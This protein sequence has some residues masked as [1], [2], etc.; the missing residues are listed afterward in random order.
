MSKV[1]NFK[2]P[3]SIDGVIEKV[4]EN[5]M[6]FVA[7]KAR[8]KQSIENDAQY[9]VALGHFISNAQKEMEKMHKLGKN[10]EAS[11]IQI[12]IFDAI[13]KY[14]ANEGLVNDKAT[15]F[16][17]VFLPM[18]EKELEESGK[19]FGG[20][21]QQCKEALFN[22]KGVENKIVGFIEKEVEKYETSADKEDVELK[23]YT[24][25]ILKRLWNKLQE[26]SQK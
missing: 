4:K 18:Y 23:N 8:M 15:H 21:L 9:L 24:Y 1:V 13:G 22:M 25:K 7:P 2:A 26:D 5:K 14:Q 12:E 17:K 3:K 20:M 10:Y 11:K 19:N 6:S 16:E